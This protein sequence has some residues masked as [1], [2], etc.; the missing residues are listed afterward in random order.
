[1]TI[2][3]DNPL[4]AS[5]DDMSAPNHPEL[6]MEQTVPWQPLAGIRVLDFSVLLPGPMAT[7]ML[8]DLGAEVIKV[9]PL[10]GDHARNVPALGPG[11]RNANR[12]KRSLALNLKHPDSAAIIRRL[13]THF[14]VAIEAF[15]P[16][17]ADRLGVGHKQLQALHPSLVYCSLSGYGQSGPW[18]DAPGHDLNYLASAGALAFSGHW[19]GKPR[20]SSLPVADMSGGSLAACAILS[21]LQERSRTGRGVYLDMSLFEATLF[22]TAMRYGLD[23]DRLIPGH[24]YPTNDLF[25][26]ADNKMI[27]LGVGTEEH[28]WINF[29]DAVASM[30]PEILELRFQSDAAR[31]Q[32]GDELAT[33]LQRLFRTRTAGEWMALLRRHEVPA[34]LCLTPEEAVESEHVRTRQMVRGSGAEASVPF[35]VWADGQRGGRWVQQPAPRLGQDGAAILQECGFTETEA[36]QFRETGVVG[37]A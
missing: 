20:R 2:T 37:G 14:D 16:G 13:V 28:F 15:R 8:A 3:H 21:A 19:F 24:P 22:F 34:S 1:M 25:E 31:R 27:A 18:R 6:N 26:T 7:V 10:T 30:A 12:N 32:H 23:G 17:V 36:R 11:F 5:T 29:R 9:E 35:P 4:Q 33:L